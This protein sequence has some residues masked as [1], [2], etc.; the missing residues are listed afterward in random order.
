M[1]S[2]ESKKDKAKMACHEC[3]ILGHFAW[4]CSTWSLSLSFSVECVQSKVQ[5]QAPVGASGL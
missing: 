4:K 5:G 1:T 3:G 2:V